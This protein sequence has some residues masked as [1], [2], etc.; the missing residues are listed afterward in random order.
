M[1]LPFLLWTL[2]ISDGQH[3]SIIPLLD[4][5]VA[6]KEGQSVTLRTTLDY[7]STVTITQS[8][9]SWSKTVGALSSETRIVFTGA[10][11][12]LI[13]NSVKLADS[14]EYTVA[15]RGRR[16]DGGFIDETAR[17]TL[18]VLGEVKIVPVWPVKSVACC[19][20]AA[21]LSVTVTGEVAP[22]N[23]RWSREETTW[24]SERYVLRSGNTELVIPDIR[25]SDSGVYVVEATRGSM[26]GNSMSGNS[27]SVD[28]MSVDSMSVDSMSEASISGGSMS[29]TTSILLNVLIGPSIN[30]DVLI[31]R[32]VGQ[33][34]DLQL[35]ISPP[36]RREEITW[37]K[38]NKEITENISLDGSRLQIHNVRTGDSGVFR[39]FVSS[40]SGFGQHTTLLSITDVPVMTVTPSTQT[41]SPGDK[42]QI[43][44][45]VSPGS[46]VTWFFN[47][48]ELPNHV[49]YPRIL[50]Y[51]VN[52]S[53]ILLLNSQDKHQGT[54]TCRADSKLFNVERSASVIVR[55]VPRVENVTSRGVVAELG[56]DAVF[57]VRLV[58]QTSQVFFS[59]SRNGESLQT[60]NARYQFLDQRRTLKLLN[61]ATSDVGVY[62]LEA[63]NSNGS[64]SLQFYLSISGR[65]S[66]PEVYH[67]SGSDTVLQGETV[68]MRCGVGGNPA[69]DVSWFFGNSLIS[70]SET[71]ELTNVTAANSGNY[72]CRGVNSIGTD[73]VTTYLQVRDTPRVNAIASPLVVEVGSTATLQV[74]VD[75]DP[76]SNPLDTE[77]TWSRKDAKLI[78]SRVS[79]ED[80]MKKLVIYNCLASDAGIYIVRASNP[81]FNYGE[82]EISL[83]VTKSPELSSPTLKLKALLGGTANFQGV[84]DALPRPDPSF[85]RWTHN[86][87]QVLMT[88]KSR[89]AI[90]RDAMSLT[91]SEIEP[92]QTGRYRFQYLNSFIEMYLDVENI[93]HIYRRSQ[94]LQTVAA[95]EEAIFFCSF[96][97]YPRPT[98]RWFGGH[99]ELFSSHPKY[100]ISP[101]G[102]TLKILN[103]QSSDSSVKYRCEVSNKVG[104]DSATFTIGVSTLPVLTALRNIIEI[105]REGSS[106]TLQV[107]VSGLPQTADITLIWTSPF[108]TEIF[109]TSGRY[110]LSNKKRKL[111][112]SDVQL[113]DAGNYVCNLYTVSGTAMQTILLRQSD[114][115]PAVRVLNDVRVSVGSTATLTA[116]TK[117]SVSSAQW[118]KD[119]VVLTTNYKYQIA[120]RLDTQELTIKSATLF[121]SGE[122]TILL[123]NFAGS[124]SASSFL[125]VVETPQFELHPVTQLLDQ[126]D[127]AVLSCTLQRG[128]IQVVKLVWKLGLGGSP[129]EITGQ[130]LGLIGG[131]YL[132]KQES[133]KRSSVLVVNNFSE[134]DPTQEVWC[135][136]ANWAGLSLSNRAKLL[137]RNNGVYLPSIILLSHPE[138]I[139]VVDVGD[140][141]TIQIKCYGAPDTIQWT[142]SPNSGWTLQPSYEN[143]VLSLSSVRSDQAGTYTVTARNSH[144][145]ATLTFKV[146]V[147]SG[148]QG[149]HVIVP[150][151]S[152]LDSQV[153]SAVEIRVLIL[154]PNFL[155]LYDLVWSRDGVIL[156]PSNR[157]TFSPATTHV[158][159]RQ[160]DTAFASLSINSV[161][162]SDS[163]V[164]QVYFSGS[165]YR[166]AAGETKLTVTAPIATN[167]DSI[168]ANMDVSAV[169]TRVSPQQSSVYPG[170]VISLQVSSPPEIPADRITWS[171]LS[172]RLPT[173]R[174]RYQDNRNTLVITGVTLEDA[175]TYRV[176]TD[177]T[178]TIEF[179]VL[180]LNSD[181]STNREQLTSVVSVTP[182]NSFLYVKL[183]ATATLSVTV[184]SSDSLSTLDI[185]WEKCNKLGQSCGGI[186]H[187][188]ALYFNYKTQLRIQTVSGGDDGLYR[189]HVTGADQ[190]TRTGD[191]TLIITGSNSIAVT[192]ERSRLTAEIGQ[193]VMM[194][195]T[196]SGVSTLDSGHVTWT[197]N[198]ETLRTDRFTTSFYTAPYRSAVVCQNVFLNEAG[199]YIVSV[200]NS[201]GSG[202]TEIVLDVLDTNSIEL[203]TSDLNLREGDT[204]IFQVIIN[205]KPTPLLSDIEWQKNSYPINSNPSSDKYRFSIDRK[206]LSVFSV[207]S[208]DAGHY[209]CRIRNT[210]YVSN[211]NHL[212]VI[213]NLSVRPLRPTVYTGYED[214]ISLSIIV[215]PV[216]AY[217]EGTIDWFKDGTSLTFGDRIR[218]SQWGRTVFISNVSLEIII[219]VLFS[220]SI[221]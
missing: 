12:D 198:G 120:S 58:S 217:T 211:S 42:L 159:A 207:T 55:E 183:G 151:Y 79:Y 177:R 144:G 43:T 175:G 37:Y 155:N 152:E 1:L 111:R 107:T 93:P 99:T 106:I 24:I 25:E 197:K 38:D 146:V 45:T 143:T 141:V 46:R 164:Y 96:T 203:V 112:I 123:S 100:D 127:S 214:D 34:V 113:T 119:N 135:E 50:V 10:F 78:D 134:Q 15:V 14:G 64:V 148:I 8:D 185:S 71:V 150:V 188:R 32:S 81:K 210:V 174:V 145:T 199:S 192:P 126:G 154:N 92:S 169:L 142:M 44:C 138:G 176:S 172:G 86:M 128:D 23:I 162:L 173:S 88:G 109:V 213:E 61:V 17:I 31:E 77:I 114:P 220:F 180:V 206:T 5:V 221:Y 101:D 36:V 130:D 181:T 4:E 49:L 153:G 20:A 108:G 205:V 208:H 168:A 136:A 26:S 202:F 167:P 52:P 140:A 19:G 9:V 63:R 91:L 76:Y 216:A 75:V 13:F 117:G 191:I 147:V 187:N 16:N 204:A 39:C 65:S 28:S 209:R 83:E 66:P 6:L 69:P 122:Y 89:V 158:T 40:S 129:L 157:Y 56:G 189:C 184:S 212:S 218:E 29:G 7:S 84:V 21:T 133:D 18:T 166:S 190:I 97:G 131:P 201:E 171:K 70:S 161:L 48:V 195:V 121:D 219:L 57:G 72:E 110:T 35:D 87:T 200:S 115:T 82:T 53:Y 94:Y 194:M 90:S 116:Y 137:S 51:G 62:T 22:E 165:Y 3:L 11:S 85:V 124:D 160:A 105:E 186:T 102:N 132:V 73:T 68:T 193:Q 67:V 196:I 125:D 163:G 27:M 60:Y 178:N 179:Y 98:V 139:V 156:Y 30:G 182:V 215:L 74:Y 103:V 95:T 170:S 54:Y 59:W 104:L 41:V 80:N 33:S 2:S 118:F 149:A 47:Q